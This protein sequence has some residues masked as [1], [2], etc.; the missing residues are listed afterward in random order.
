MAI[1]NYGDVVARYPE[2]AALKDATQINCHY[3]PYAVADIESRLAPRFT[4]PFSSNNLTAK[5][6]MVDAVY[7]AVYRFKDP[8]KA[9]A[10]EKRIAERIAALLAG[11]ADMMLSDGTTLASVGGTIYST[12]ENYD[13]VFSMLPVEDAVVDPGQLQDEWDARN[14]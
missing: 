4:V 9:E 2:Q 3:I 11:K 5:D 1:I 12:T 7:A 14:L 13:P 8:K 6:L 10:V